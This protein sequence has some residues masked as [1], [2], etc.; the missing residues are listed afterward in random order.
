[1][2]S[3]PTHGS[4]YLF[5]FPFLVGQTNKILRSSII[6]ANEPTC[7]VGDCGFE[8]HLLHQFRFYGRVA[9]LDSRVT[10]RK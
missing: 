7:Q 5:L 9:Q 10:F 4:N 8:S 2:G 1:M 6:M 3:S